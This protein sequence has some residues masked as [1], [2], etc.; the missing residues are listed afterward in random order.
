MFPKSI[1]AVVFSF[2]GLRFV[3][4]FSGIFYQNLEVI[5]YLLPLQTHIT[6]IFCVPKNKT[7]TGNVFQIKSQLLSRLDTP[8]RVTPS[9]SKIDV[10]ILIIKPLKLFLLPENLTGSLS[11]GSAVKI[12]FAL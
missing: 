12:F 9:S 10:S 5:S 6:I 7:K 1:I 4:S 3:Y 8:K 2:N 11:D